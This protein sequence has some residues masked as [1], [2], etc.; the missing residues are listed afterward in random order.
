MVTLFYEPGPK[1]LSQKK[2]LWTG[3]T[4]RSSKQSLNLGAG[5]TQG[6]NVTLSMGNISLKRFSSLWDM[7]FDRN[8]TYRI[9][10]GDEKFHIPSRGRRIHHDANCLKGQSDF[11]RVHPQIRR[12]R[13]RR[14]QCG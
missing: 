13:G 14:Q 2:R 3:C 6:V 1:G 10:V 7:R 8:D 12:K 4:R 5:A 11:T 9:W